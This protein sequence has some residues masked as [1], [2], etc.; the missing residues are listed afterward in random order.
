MLCIL[1]RENEGG[2]ALDIHECSSVSLPDY[3]TSSTEGV[4][5]I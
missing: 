3:I 4:A 5:K 2:A 1:I